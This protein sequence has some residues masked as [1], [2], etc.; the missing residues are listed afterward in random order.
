MES[1]TDGKSNRHPIGDV[2]ALETG[3][4]TYLGPLRRLAGDL[5]VH[6]TGPVPWPELAAHYAAGDVFAMPCRT[7]RGGLDVEGFGIVFLEASAVGLPVVA[8]ISGGS[9]DAVRDGETG[10][11]VDG[12]DPDALTDRLVTL[13]TDR[14]LARRMGRAGRAWVEANWRWEIQAARMA[15]MLSGS[16]AGPGR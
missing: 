9:P 3:R 16:P 7:R 8:G 15:A 6:F 1:L 14:D 12:R 2:S 10:Y 4:V 13:L 11:L 5:P